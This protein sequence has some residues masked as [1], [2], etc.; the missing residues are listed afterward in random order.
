MRYKNIGNRTLIPKPD[1]SGYTLINAKKSPNFKATTSLGAARAALTRR[2]VWENVESLV[3]EPPLPQPTNRQLT[4]DHSL[5]QPLRPLPFLL[6]WHSVFSK[7]RDL[8]CFPPRE[9]FGL[10]NRGILPLPWRFDI[11]MKE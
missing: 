10:R 11:I 2:R 1:L 4:P 6:L 8:L 5:M 7:Q 3:E 9:A